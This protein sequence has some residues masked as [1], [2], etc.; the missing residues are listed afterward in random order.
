MRWRVA[1]ELTTLLEHAELDEDAEGRLARR[2]GRE[3]ALITRPERLRTVARDLVRHF[4]GRGFTGK[5]MYVGIDKAAAVRMY[6]LVHDAWVEH[7]AELQVEHDGLP[8]LEQ[9]CELFR[10]SRRPGVLMAMDVSGLTRAAVAA[11]G[12]IEV[13]PQ[14]GDLVS[15]GEPLF[16]LSGGARSIPP[17]QLTLSGAAAA[18]EAA[19]A[20]VRPPRP[21]TPHS[22]KPR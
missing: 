12:S 16:R 13:I 3:Y 4:V 5:A 9:P 17:A 20:P 6:D 7:L 19:V 21:P 10:H 2:F 14:V 11:S 15:P 18:V 8:E 22:G 1:D